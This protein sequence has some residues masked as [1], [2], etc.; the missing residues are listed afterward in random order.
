M[1]ADFICICMVHISSQTNE[2]LLCAEHPWLKDAPDRPIHS[3]VLSRMKQ[4]KAMNKLK[5]LALKVNTLNKKNNYFFA[6]VKLSWQIVSF[7]GKVI[8]ENLSPEEIKGLKQMFNNMD[9]DKSGT[10]TVE[11]LKEGLR[12]LG[13]KISEAEVQKLMEAVRLLISFHFQPFTKLSIWNASIIIRWCRLTW[14]RVAAL[15]TRSSLLPWWI[16]I[17]WKRRRI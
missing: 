5:Q 11:E 8:A 3:A 12:K 13:S 9:T 15:I 16:N 1:N 7:H 14:T 17:N 6:C 10:I 2:W 4:F